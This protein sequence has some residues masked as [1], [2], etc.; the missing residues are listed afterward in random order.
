MLHV[1]II[2]HAVSGS[3]LTLLKQAE[4]ARKDG[5]FWRQINNFRTLPEFGGSSVKADGC[6]L[7]AVAGESDGEHLFRALLRPVETVLVKLLPNF[8]TP[9]EGAEGVKEACRHR[10]MC[11]TAGLR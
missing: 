8:Y 4:V 6:D 11:L 10:R 2:P 3:V 9:T 1:S 5:C 7:E